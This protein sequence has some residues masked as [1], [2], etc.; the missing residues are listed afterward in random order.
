VVPVLNVPPP[1]QGGL[2]QLAPVP[3][4]QYNQQ[5]ATAAGRNETRVQDPVQMALHFAEIARNTPEK[6]EFNEAHIPLRHEAAGLSTAVETTGLHDDSIE[7][8][9]LAL[10]L[11]R[12]LSGIWNV[13]SANKGH[14]CWPGRGHTNYSAEP[15]L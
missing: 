6:W 10:L 11:H 8:E 12:G 5:V 9:K 1:A 14:R 7:G 3:A 13:I 4:T 2:E 15:C